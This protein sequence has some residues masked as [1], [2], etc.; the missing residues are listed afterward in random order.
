MRG[1]I[2]GS[3]GVS[4]VLQVRRL[5]SEGGGFCGWWGKTR[6]TRHRPPSPHPPLL[7]HPLCL[8]RLHGTGA[9]ALWEGRKGGTLSPSPGHWGKWPLLLCSRE[10]CLTFAG[11]EVP[12]LQALV[13]LCI[14]FSGSQ[15]G[16]N[17]GAEV[18]KQGIRL[19]FTAPLL[20][21]RRGQGA[22]SF[23]LWAMCPR[24]QL[25]RS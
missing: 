14:H 4:L 20:P 21:T 23:S 6:Q 5:P 11:G 1:A 15:T 10:D 2:L 9:G 13:A 8:Q 16:S 3:Q 18:R 7:P 19:I 12:R 22:G 25:V 24:L 17:P